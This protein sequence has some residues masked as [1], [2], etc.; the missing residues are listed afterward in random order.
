MSPRVR[1]T[2]L[3]GCLLALLACLLPATAAAETATSSGGA[4][5]DDPRYRPAKKAKIVNG[6]AVPPKGAPK[7][8]VAVINAA[9]KIARKPYRYGGGHASFND[10]GYDC[11]GSVSYVLHGA[12]KLSSPLASGGLM[13]YGNPG[14]GKHIT[15]YANSGHA[16]MV[17]DGRRFDTTGREDDGTRWEGESRSTAGYVARHPPGL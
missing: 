16:F 9:N 6:L 5:P 13:S 15:V 4:S 3:A 14:K 2:L 1:T 10:S 7:R 11:S 17:I 8:V 12:G